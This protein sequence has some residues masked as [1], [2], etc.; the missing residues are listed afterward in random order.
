ML[1][2]LFS[3]ML[4]DASRRGYFPMMRSAIT[5]VF[6]SLMLAGCLASGQTRS[7]AQ[8]GLSPEEI[9][10]QNREAEAAEELDRAMGLFH[11]GE[12]LD[13]ETAL[14]HLDKAVE[15]DPT[16]LAARQQRAILLQE[17]GRSDEALADADYILIERPENVRARF[18]KGLILYQRGD[19]PAAVREFSRA[20]ELDRTLSEAYALRGSAYSQMERYDD[21][22]HD[23]TEAIAFN[24]A[25]ARAYYNRGMAHMRMEA[26]ERALHDFTQALSLRSQSLDI[27]L[28]RGTVAMRLR[29]VER[30]ATD[31]K[32]AAALD[33][34]DGRLFAMLGE[35]YAA[36]ERYA[37]ALVAARKAMTLLKAEGD[38]DG[39]AALEDQISR[40]EAA[41]ER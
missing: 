31:F 1:F 38:E 34:D 30:A 20:L 26:N 21:A 3:F 18:T 29:L 16:L 19:Y 15:M 24:P 9:A 35:A 23:F 32:R 5:I 33:P 12:F 27:L 41:T 37:M 25:N 39:V 28:A 6:L 13:D 7:G 40:Y 14:A 8:V 10:R 17:R 2:I 22:V 36:G 11:D 4:T